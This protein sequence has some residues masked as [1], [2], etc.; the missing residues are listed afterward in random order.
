[1]TDNLIPAKVDVWGITANESDVNRKDICLWSVSLNDSD[2]KDLQVNSIYNTLILKADFKCLLANY[3][4]KSGTYGLRLRLVQKAT[5]DNIYPVVQEIELDSGSMFGN[6]YSFLVYS[7]QEATF[8]ISNIGTIDAISLYL[9]QNNDFEY[10]KHDGF[11]ESVPEADFDNILVKNIYL[12]FGSDLTKIEDNTLQ[13]F[14]GDSA[15]YNGDENS[16]NSR[17]IGLLWYNKNEDNTY[18]GFSDGIYDP[19]Y[20]EIQ[21]LKDT[22]QD[23]RLVS[24][25]GKDVPTDEAGL[26]VSADL[27]EVLPLLKTLRDTVTR[28]LNTNVRAFQ[29]QVQTISQATNLGDSFTTVLN[30]I[31]TTGKTIT[32]SRDTLKE[33]YTAILSAARKIQDNLVEDKPRQ[34]VTFTTFETAVNNLIQLV[35]SLMTNAN[36][37]IKKDYTGYMSVYD[38]YKARIDKVIESLNRQLTNI[39]ILISDDASVMNR[40]FEAR[41]TFIPY[42][43]EDLSGYAN[44]YCIYWY[45]YQPNYY[46]VEE[47][48]MEKGWRRL[49]DINLGIPRE[50]LSDDSIYNAKKTLSDSVFVADLNTEMVEEKF[51]A[52]LFYNHTMYKSNIIT[53]TNGNPPVDEKTA[54]LANG[55]C[56]IEHSDNSQPSYQVYGLNN[57]ILNVADVSYKRKLLVR[58]EGLNTG[59]E[60]LYGAQ[61]FWYVPTN[62][63]MLSYDVKDF[64]EEWSNDGGTA[65]GAHSKQ[66]FIC[67]YRTIGGSD[68]KDENGD[69]LRYEIND[70]D[71]YF[72]YRI[73]D[74]YSQTFTRNTIECKVI[75]MDG[76]VLETDISF[77]FSSFGTSGTD[78]TLVV[79]PRTTKPAVDYNAEANV[80]LPLGLAL[81]DYNNERLKIYDTAANIGTEDFVPYLNSLRW[82]GP[83]AYNAVFTYLEGEKKFGVENIDISVR[84][85]K[86]PNKGYYPG[87]LEVTVPYM[88][89]EVDK[90]VDLVTIYPIPYR[91]GDYYI[92]GASVVVYQSDGTNPGYYKN[93]FKIF[94]MDTNEEITTVKWSIVCYDEDGNLIDWGSKKDPVLEGFMPKLDSQ[95]RLVPCHIYLED[96]ADG[97]KRESYPVVLCTLLKQN[98]KGDWEEDD[99]LWAQPIYCMK[100]RYASAMLNK[101]DGSFQIDEENGTILSTMLG[102][103]RKNSQNQFEGILMG[104]VGSASEDN[105]SGVGLYGFHNGAQSFNFNVDGT[106]FI[107]KSGRGRIKFNGNTGSITS[108][109]YEETKESAGMKIDLDDGYIDIRGVNQSEDGKYNKYESSG[110][111]IDVKSPYLTVRSELGNELVHIGHEKYELQSD[112][113]IETEFTLNEVESNKLTT[114]STDKAGTGM[115]LDLKEGT[116][117]AFNFYLISKNV[118]LNSKDSQKP[119]FVIKDDYNN[120]LM[121]IGNSKFWLKSADYSETAAGEPEA[122]MKIDLSTGK[123]DAFNFSLVSSRVKLSTSGTVTKPYLEIV[124]NDTTL[125]HISEAGQYIRSNNFSDNKESGMEINLGSGDFTAYTFELKAGNSSEG[126][127]RMS[128]TGTGGSGYPL[129]LGTSLTNAKFK[130]DWAGNLYCE[131]MNAQNANLSGTLNVG[132]SLTVRGTLT[133]GIINGAEITGGKININ[134]KFTVDSNGRLVCTSANIGGWEVANTSTGGFTY[135]EGNFSVTPTGLNFNNMLKVASNG[136]TTIKDLIVT[137]T[138]HFQSCKVGI[139]TNPSASY[140]L[141]VGGKS[142][143]AGKVGIGA[144]PNDSYGLYISGKVLIGGQISTVTNGTT[145]TAINGS[146]KLDGAGIFDDVTLKFRNGLLVGLTGASAGG[147]TTVSTIPSVSGQSGKFLT[148]DGSKLSWAYVKKKFN[149]TMTGRVKDLY[150][151]DDKVWCYTD[152]D[153]DYETWYDSDGY[154]YSVPVYY[155]AIGGAYRYSRSAVNTVTLQGVSSAITLD[156]STTNS[157]PIEITITGATQQ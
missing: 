130:V 10:Y 29:E 62:T 118:M 103:G 11:V 135:P 72:I 96:N 66:G 74:Y 76:T 155:K 92:E 71:R 115:K 6:P 126:F 4:M 123:I 3:R 28:D 43:K 136:K 54:D 31:S 153:W 68:I 32:E 70:A 88:I 58:Y 125:M 129:W 14:T 117:D 1:M 25:L 142:W 134:N 151:T 86:G 139:N 59:D 49:E 17:E 65:V 8:D 110:I 106:A 12:S 145:E 102:A 107:G 22:E 93:P 104:D 18:I 56:R 50:K 131:G 13:I 35:N 44:K 101:W 140:D 98:N 47:R 45:R 105:A 122:G 73:K 23:S 154:R 109:S 15:I 60:M 7:T 67:F 143:L 87:I 148:T 69:H 80:N 90:E 79:S 55:A 138:A 128:S 39:G 89:E 77:V 120:M 48:F 83:T 97:N 132:E 114:P 63:T 61:V 156:S 119:Y 51:I 149:V 133:G 108:A 150:T 9:Y 36:T 20:D 24:Q 100:N 27:E 33:E 38:T 95:N 141:A 81:Y 40:F 146:F 116:L 144:A 99:V 46:D 42:V 2:F 64:S 53:F 124:G 19:T 57:L 137:D 152:I 147:D 82:L 75:L 121:H 112:Q 16:S 157:E 111:R 41:Y 21:Y 34:T 5:N 30:S 91:A 84:G 37:L 26:T 85:D 94:R 127:L 52:V 113:Y 78:Y